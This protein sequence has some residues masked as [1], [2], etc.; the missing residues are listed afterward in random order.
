MS[1][2]SQYP[3]G[4]LISE[5]IREHASSEVAFVAQQLGYRD[6]E[7]GLRRLHLW[8]ETG[9]GH[10][11]VIRQIARATGRDEDLEAAIAATTEMKRNE[12]EAEFLEHC[13]G[14][15]ATFRPFLSAFGS[16]TVPEGICIFGMTGGFKRWTI[17][18]LPDSLLDLA[19]E[20]QIP[21]L[22]P[23]MVRYKEQHSGQVPFFGVLSGFKL[24]RLLDYIQFD[25][26]GRFVEHVQKPFRLGQCSVRLA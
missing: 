11:R 15:A 22:Q 26:D 23:F 10:Q 6:A 24:V 25:T 2:A 8:T 12:W 13:R 3:I 4:Q 17:T 7:K 1:S 9:E 20:E 21:A 19:L 16:H 18:E 14:E 5:I